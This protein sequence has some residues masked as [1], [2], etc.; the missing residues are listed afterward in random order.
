MRV[1]ARCTLQMVQRQMFALS[2]KN[3]CG[4]RDPC[5]QECS[6]FYINRGGRHN[7]LL[8]SVKLLAAL[9]HLSVSKALGQG[10]LRELK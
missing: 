9:L 5:G 7:K 6:S 4:R 1:S 3:R 2:M 10:N 8:R